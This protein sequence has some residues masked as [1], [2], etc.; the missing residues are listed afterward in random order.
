MMKTDVCNIEKLQHILI[1]L[2]GELYY[3]VKLITH[4]LRSVG[5]EETSDNR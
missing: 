3:F 5:Y 2:Y 1:Y 4:D